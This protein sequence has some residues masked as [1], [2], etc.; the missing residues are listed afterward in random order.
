MITYTKTILEPDSG[1][2]DV[3]YVEGKCVSS[4]QKPTDVAN[5]STLLE[6]DT[7]KVYMFDVDASTWREWS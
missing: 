3:F 2:S 5:G 7:S 4:D 1:G 6:M